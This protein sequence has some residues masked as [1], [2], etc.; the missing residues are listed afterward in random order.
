M[1][2]RS[3]A[4]KRGGTHSVKDEHKTNTVYDEWNLLQLRSECGVRGIPW[5]DVRKHEMARKLADGD[6]EKKRAER[7][8]LVEYQRNQQALEREKQ[9]ENDRQ[10]K[11]DAERHKKR[12]ERQARR[13]LGEEVSDETPDEDELQLMKEDF[14]DRYRDFQ[15][16]VGGE[17]LSEESWDSS[18]T[19][20][21]F[22]SSIPAIVPDC[23]LR[24]FEWTYV[25]MPSPV[26]RPSTNS[27][28]DWQRI[29]QSGYKILSI[30]G[31]PTSP[32]SNASSSP[33]PPPSSIAMG[34][35]PEP[36]PR[37]VPYAPLK[38]HTSLSKEKLFL[39]GQTY[40]PGVDPDYVPL[41]SPRT[42]DAARN[43]HLLGVLRKATIEPA[44]SWT[45]RTQIQGWNARMFFSLPP[46]NEHKRLA[47][48]YT[49]W[50][51]ENRKLLRVN[52]LTAPSKQ[53][54]HQRHAQRHK[55]KP[56]KFIEV[57]EAS[58]YRP[59]AICYLPAYL[60]FSRDTYDTNNTPQ[61]LRNLY[62][63]RFPGCDVPHY[64]FWTKK[65]E[66]DDPTTRNPEWRWDPEDVK[67]R[68]FVSGK[69]LPR[70]NSTRG[71]VQVLRE[72]DLEALYR[73][74]SVPE[75]L[76]GEKCEV[77]LEG[78]EGGSLGGEM[79]IRD[80]VE[81][82][83]SGL[84]IGADCEEKS[85]PN[86]MN[87]MCPFCLEELRELAVAVCCRLSCVGVTG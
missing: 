56:K 19:E 58:A 81:S 46:R 17:A 38:I 21:S 15:G 76:M 79:E 61:T 40:P 75:I 44:T 80:E 78:L 11:A 29:N 28:R 12:I 14:D 27:L 84:E 30:I 9:K 62:Y 5:K 8:A 23:R 63:I 47:D 50:M 25:E 82:L 13:D 77:W 42:Q 2:P 49:K 31:A 74:G 85:L 26:A 57:L 37:A 22:C 3:A 48:V 72:G 10:L 64:Y 67:S 34:K 66:W 1:A 53:S 83:A 36:T 16:A 70:A 65:G 35:R 20:S 4:H 7:D 86:G 18:S 55:N 43:G 87:L 52:P 39:P 68:R 32:T 41:I 71:D 54:R 24:L 33:S 73:R 59:T 45:S 51:L 60:D 69:R 6:V